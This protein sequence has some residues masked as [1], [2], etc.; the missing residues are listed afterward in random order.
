MTK[1]QKKTLLELEEKEKL[2]FN[3]SQHE[4]EKDF[5]L[6]A[7]WLKNEWKNLFTRL[8][9]FQV[10]FMFTSSNERSRCARS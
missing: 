4:K 3:R 2:S 8:Q 10:L 6:S 9:F 1:N 5:G 7:I